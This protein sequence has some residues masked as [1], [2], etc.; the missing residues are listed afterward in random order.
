MTTGENHSKS[1]DSI[2]L[3]CDGKGQ[4]DDRRVHEHAP[5][6]HVV[7]LEHLGEAVGDHAK[8]HPV[9]AA[10][11]LDAAIGD[12]LPALSARL[13]HRA[14]LRLERLGVL[15]EGLEGRVRRVEHARLWPERYLEVGAG[16]EVDGRHWRRR[17]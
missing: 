16:E 5:D 8:H 11:V 1:L 3:I 15:E 14:V 12:L 4:V 17:F 2:L 13:E 7:L 6:R 9:D 10:H